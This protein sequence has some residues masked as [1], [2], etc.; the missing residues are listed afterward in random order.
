M[1]PTPIIRVDPRQPDGAIIRKAADL[2]RAGKLVVFPTETV[3]GLGAN[4]MDPAAVARIFEAKHRPPNNP[5]I[6]HVADATDCSRVVYQWPE[7][8]RL[9]A[10]SFWPGP[11]TLVLPKHPNLPAI[12][13]AG[14]PTVAVRS[15]AHPVAQSLLKAAGIPIAAPSANPSGELS[16]TTAEH[17]L[18]GLAGRVD[19]ILD[20][21]ATQV[22]VESTVVDLTSDPPRLLRP[23][24]IGPAEIEAVI[25]P[26]VRRDIGA[27]IAGVPLPSPGLLAKHYSPRTTLQGVEP[28]GDANLVRELCRNGLRVGW[29]R[30]NGHLINP[31][32]LAIR[33]PDDPAAYAARLLR[34][35][36][37]WTASA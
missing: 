31:T 20:A 29:V 28:T 21:G 9:L 33:L 8:A 23:G 16:P 34:R 36:T 22:G 25:G 3:Y 10:E 26:I 27:R 5:L 35:C 32:G 2:L 17:V 30:S 13:S 6:V 15:P 11:L 4:A 7:R 24:H 1:F 37:N 18:S 12:V 19:L 14:G